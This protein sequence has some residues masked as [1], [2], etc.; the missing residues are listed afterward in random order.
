VYV[1]YREVSN[2]TKLLAHISGFISG[3]M[4][5]ISFLF[6]IQHWPGANILMFAGVV[7]TGLLFLPSLFT[8]KLKTAENSNKRLIYLLA[9]V[10][11]FVYLAGFLFKVE[12]W[13]G[14]SIMMITGSLI[15]L[16]IAFPMYIF[17]KYKDE[18]SVNVNFIFI[19]VAVTWI[20]IPTLLI[21]LNLSQDS[22]RIFK[23]SNEESAFLTQSIGLKN[24]KIYEK[25]SSSTV[26]D[27][28]VKK[29][30]FDSLKLQ[31]DAIIAYLEKVKTDVAKVSDTFNS[32]G[33]INE[34]LYGKNDDGESKIISEKIAGYR[35]YLIFLLGKDNSKE[36][37]LNSILSINKI[38]MIPE[39]TKVI[40]NYQQISFDYMTTINK[41]SWLQEDIKVAEGIVFREFSRQLSN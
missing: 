27:K 18:K 16:V 29:A 38:Q 8:S 41:L 4:I 34:L 36:H 30:T 7:I 17:N 5:S 39:K 25:L 26:S 23:Q 12:H 19:A 28:G 22:L 24:D 6:K 37:I 10:G 3:F 21:S 9:W 14:A 2:K 20:I 35:Q 1:S 11:S 33:A 15:G 31:S 13:P 40:G 32:S